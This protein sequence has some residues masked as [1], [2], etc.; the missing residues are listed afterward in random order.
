[1]ACPGG[2]R[3]DSFQASVAADDFGGSAPY[4]AK[5]QYAPQ[6][7]QDL[8]ACVIKAEATGKS[9]KA[10]GSRYSF[11]HA[12]WSDDILVDTSA[13]NRHLSQPT[14]GALPRARRDTQTAKEI[15]RFRSPAA[16][17]R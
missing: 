14:G 9:L 12:Y 8:V 3:T 4:T 5:G 10:C 11:S 2:G 15:Q 1:M 7:L 6:T 16:G 13:L 17:A